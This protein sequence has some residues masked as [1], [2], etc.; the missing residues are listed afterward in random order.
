MGEDT[1]RRLGEILKTMELVTE[2]Q[3]Q[4]SLSLQ[5]LDGFKIG[6]IFVYRGLI[7]EDELEMAL[8]YQE[9]A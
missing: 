9:S 1:A 4:E 7:S 8:L 3:I 5:R 6:Q 2:Q